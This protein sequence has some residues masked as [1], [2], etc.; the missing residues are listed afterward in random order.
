MTSLNRAAMMMQGALNGMQGQG[1]SG[2]AGLLGRLGQMANQQGGINSGTQGAMGMGNSGQGM[3]SQ[4]QAEYQRLA[5]EQAAVRKSLDE[6]S[7]EAKNAGEFSKLLG[8][9]DQIAKQM[10][11]VQTNLVQGEVN[12]ETIQ[13]QDRILSRL[14]DAARST[15]E[16]DYEQRR[17]SETGKALQQ[18]SPQ[19]IDLTTQEG[20]NK[21]REELLKIREGKYSKDFEELIRRYFEQLEKEKIA[22]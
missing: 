11:E 17:R 9:L 18:A 13:K 10:Q 4:Q 20:K 14:L 5:G 19:D 16:R 6:L 15:R 1:G 8:D 22:Q 7:K 21:F 3:T 12:P 2:M